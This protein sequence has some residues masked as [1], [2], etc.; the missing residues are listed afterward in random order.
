MLMENIHADIDP[1]R[2]ALKTGLE[3]FDKALEA[4]D[5]TQRNQPE[6]QAM[7]VTAFGF[8]ITP[9]SIASF[10]QCSNQ[11]ILN[12]AG[13]R[14]IPPMQDTR[15]RLRDALRGFVALKLKALN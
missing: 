14:P 4:Y 12:W 1:Y 13:G 9:N 3:M 15:V 11:S 7:L 6:F 5:P 8:G 2:Q 10:M